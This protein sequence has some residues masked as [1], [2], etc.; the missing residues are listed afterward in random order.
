M[1]LLVLLGH[2]LSSCSKLSTDSVREA[3]RQIL[4]FSSDKKRNF[5]E[6]VELQIALKNYDAA[7]DKRIAGQVRLPTVPK[8]KVRVCIIGDARACDQAKEYGLEHMSEDD[9]KKLNRDKKLVKKLAKSYD[10]FLASASLIKKIPRLVGR[11]P[12]TMPYLRC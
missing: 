3:V 4:E 9:L 12:L 5:T 8:P 11:A 2:D 1:L 7:R 6:T 10:A